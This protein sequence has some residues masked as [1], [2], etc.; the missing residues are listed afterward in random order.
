MN[1]LKAA[2]VLGFARICR[3]TARHGI[4]SKC[5][6]CTPYV[7]VS[8]GVTE[9]PRKAVELGPLAVSRLRKPG[10]YSVGGAAG[11]ALQVSPGGARSWILNISIG[12]KRREMGLGGFPG[13]PLA[14]AREATREA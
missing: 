1:R 12:G 6:K 8:V 5:T 11:L 4:S 14:D 13:V 10:L 9:M 3:I 7:G 2:W